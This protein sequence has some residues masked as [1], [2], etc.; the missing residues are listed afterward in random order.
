MLDMHVSH[1]PQADWQLVVKANGDV[2][3]NERIDQKLTLP[4]KGWASIQIDLSRFAG[5][6]VYL[7]V[8]NQSNGKPNEFAYW[9]R[10]AVVDK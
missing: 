7:E 8:L 5:Q 6:K 10:I 3:H 2:I 4:Q 1:Y 9:K